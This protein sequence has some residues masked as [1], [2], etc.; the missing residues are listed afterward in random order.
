M[1][2]EPTESFK[3]M[4]ETMAILQTLVGA[5]IAFGAAYFSAKYTK[6]RESLLALSSRE[7]ERIERIYYLL[8]LVRKDVV[9]D[10]RQVMSHIDSNTKYQE[11]CDLD[12]PPMLE[13]EMLV[14]LYYPELNEYLKEL[15]YSEASFIL[16]KLDFLSESYEAASKSQKQ[17][18][19]AKVVELTMIFGD[20]HEQFQ[21]KLKEL[22]KV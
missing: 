14:R 8:V 17:K 1:A 2:V 21:A 7:R 15:K 9:E 12:F 10:A 22:A 5:G 19:S 13:I 16:K 18:D 3:Y 6:D 20:A 4:S 11:R